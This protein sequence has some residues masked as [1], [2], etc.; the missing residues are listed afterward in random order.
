M[1]RTKEELESIGAVDT[2]P[3]EY[4]STQVIKVFCAHCKVTV[5]EKMIVQ[6][7]SWK[8]TRG[9]T[10]FCDPCTNIKK[11]EGSSRPRKPR[12]I[13][14]DFQL[15]E[16]GLIDSSPRNIRKEEFVDVICAGG[17]NDVQT[18]VFGNVCDS[19]RHNKVGYK[20]ASCV[21]KARKANKSN[22]SGKI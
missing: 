21:V 10:I 18:K 11:S 15:K 5:K 16:R 9:F 20:C 3:G 19:F 6:L 13:W 22:E 2:T 8:K 14:S 4:K 7:F 1:F 12:A 17:C